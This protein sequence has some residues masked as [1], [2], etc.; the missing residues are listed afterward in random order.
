MSTSVTAPPPGV[1]LQDFSGANQIFLT[2][3][4]KTFP[5]VQGME[6]E[7]VSETANANAT[8]TLTYDYTPAT[9]VPE[10]ASGLLFGVGG[11]VWYWL[12]RRR[13]R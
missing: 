11:P 12:Y 10:P 2:L 1:V 4:A 13:R 5:L 8:V 6:N 7:S 3:I 9:A